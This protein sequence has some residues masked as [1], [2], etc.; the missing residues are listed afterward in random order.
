MST[1]TKVILLIG[2]PVGLTAGYF[3]GRL[4]NFLMRMTD[5]VYAFPALLL[6]IVMQVAFGDYMVGR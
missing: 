6:A 5:V 2:V 3:G 4:D 1:R